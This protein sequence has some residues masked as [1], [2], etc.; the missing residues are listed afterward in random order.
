M[1]VTEMSSKPVTTKYGT[2]KT[3][4][5]KADGD[6][7]KCGFK[8]PP[9]KEGDEVTFKFTEGTYGREVDMD[10]ISIGGSASV[11]PARSGSTGSTASAPRSA[12]PI[13][14]LDGQRSIIR[15]NCVTQ[16]RE[17]YVGSKGGKVFDFTPATADEVIAMAR[18]FEAY[19]AGELDFVRA[20]APAAMKEEDIAF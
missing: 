9:F 15:Q 17:L 3:Y 18:K 12:F 16:A 20:S 1:K 6:W 19:A 2:K 11:P 5:F 7:Y 14:P 4:S 13:S 10:S 8:V